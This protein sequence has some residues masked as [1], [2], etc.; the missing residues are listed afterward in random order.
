MRPRALS[1]AGLVLA[2][3][4][5]ASLVVIFLRA[6]LFPLSE[7]PVGWFSVGYGL[8]LAT[9]FYVLRRFALTGPVTSTFFGLWLLSLI[10]MPV[11]AWRFDHAILTRR[12]ELVER[13]LA[14]IVSQLEL[15]RSGRGPELAPAW[16]EPVPLALPARPRNAPERLVYCRLGAR[17]TITFLGEEQTSNGL[18][19]A[20]GAG[21]CSLT[22]RSCRDRKASLDRLSICTAYAAV[23]GQMIERETALNLFL[24][25]AKYVAAVFDRNGDHQIDR[26]ELR[27]I[28]P[29]GPANSDPRVRQLELSMDSDGDGRVFEGELI[30]WLNDAIWPGRSPAERA[31]IPRIR[32]AKQN[33]ERLVDRPV[34]AAP[35][36]PKA[37][38]PRKVQKVAP[39]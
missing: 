6:R 26:D 11:M 15:E 17:A 8:Y 14:G 21:W 10:S 29:R 38:S 19:F 28:R 12:T 22:E 20:K 13:A 4:L 1:K 33:A 35:K 23:G 7:A 3:V 25:D 27:A 31:L 5:F 24:V 39:L 9:A 16:L 2:T 18:H 37:Q 34:K 30:A 36:R 32:P